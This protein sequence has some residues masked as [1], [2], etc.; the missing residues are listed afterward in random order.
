[1]ALGKVGVLI[2]MTS[3]NSLFLYPAQCSDPAIYRS[4]SP[5]R[6]QYRLAPPANDVTPFHEYQ[7]LRHDS[8][9]G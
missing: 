1:M 7:A 6:A 4:R 5:Q 8:M 2:V 3:T 9:F